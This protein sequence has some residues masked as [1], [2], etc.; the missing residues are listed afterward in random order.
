MLSGGPALKRSILRFAFAAG[1]FLAAVVVT[2]GQGRAAGNVCN[3][4][5]TTT[6]GGDLIAAYDVFSAA[7]TYSVSAGTVKFKCTQLTT[8]PTTVTIYFL[9]A[10]TTQG[11]YTPPALSG[12]GNSSLQ[13]SLCLPL[14]TSA[15]CALGN[16]SNAWN[17]TNGFAISGV[18]T[19]TVI[20]VPQFAAFAAQQNVYVGAAYSTSVNFAFGCGTPNPTPC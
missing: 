12:P 13:F 14:V 5:Q 9:G 18:T 4:T 8:S 16:A 6:L 3:L 19:Q 11:V 7:K 17:A 20:S 15:N 1:L 2:H 10:S